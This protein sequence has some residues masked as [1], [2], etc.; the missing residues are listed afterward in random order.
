[1][2]NA[3][4]VQEAI[5]L[6]K[7]TTNVKDVSKTTGLQK[8]TIILLI[9]SD[10]EMIERVI[11]SFL[12]DKG[13]VLEEPF[14]NELKRSIELRDKYLSDQRTRMEGAEEEGIRM[15]IEI[16]R[17]IGREQIAIKVA[18]SML[19][20]KLSLEEILTIQN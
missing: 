2:K 20:K 18:K 4:K 15:G 8:E 14:V 19:A 3:N 11:K 16:S 7:R 6:L 13:Y 5:E 12:N 17:K 9:E 10:S 1:M